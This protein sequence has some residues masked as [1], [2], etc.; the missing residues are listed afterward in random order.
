[1]ASIVHENIDFKHLRIQSHHQQM[2]HG[3]L[4]GSPE[5]AP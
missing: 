5:E 3:T 2:Q 1:M 4:P